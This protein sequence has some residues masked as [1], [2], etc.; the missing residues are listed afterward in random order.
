MKLKML[1]NGRKIKEEPQ[2]STTYQEVAG[3]LCCFTTKTL[4]QINS[5]F[6]R[7]FLYKFWRALLLFKNILLYNC[8]FI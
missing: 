3:E 2:P 4:M 6:I 8:T 1:G 7:I 5:T